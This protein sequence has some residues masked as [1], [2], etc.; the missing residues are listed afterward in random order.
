MTRY[1]LIKFLVWIG[2]YIRIGMKNLLSAV[3]FQVV[4]YDAHLISVSSSGPTIS[5][6]L[7]KWY[8]H[9]THDLGLV[10]DVFPVRFS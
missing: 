3:Y 1:T 5:F 4:H 9:K 8:F 7:P 10:I 2:T 6:L